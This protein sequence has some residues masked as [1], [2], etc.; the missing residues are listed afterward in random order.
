MFCFFW[1]E[2][3]KASTQFIEFSLPEAV[4]IVNEMK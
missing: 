2:D 4:I 1:D 3:L